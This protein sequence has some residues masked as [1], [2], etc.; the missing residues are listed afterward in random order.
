MSQLTQQQQKLLDEFK[1]AADHFLALVEPL[2]EDELDQ[3][4]TDGW[5]IRQI[6]HHVSDDGDVW[7][8]Q[9]KRALATPGALLKFEG[10]PGNDVWIAA[11]QCETRSVAPQLTLIRAHNRAMAALAADFP[12][13]WQRA[14]VFQDEQGAPSGSASVSDMLTFLSEHMLEHAA[15]V[16]R[17]LKK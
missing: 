10:F 12:N 6:V 1:A 14:V 2:G 16:E 8:F 5:S 13:A 11:L 3:R 7:A 15:T 9:M 4:E 17:I